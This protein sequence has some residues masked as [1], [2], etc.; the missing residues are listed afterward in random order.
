MPPDEIPTIS[1]EVITYYT[2]SYEEA[3]RFAPGTASG[4]S[5]LEFTRAQELLRARLLPLPVAILD[6]AGGPGAYVRWLTCGGYAVHLVDP[7][8]KHVD[9]ARVTDRVDRRGTDRQPVCGLVKSGPL[10]RVPS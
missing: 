2:N 8:P 1:S 6:V 7:V 3:D 9:Q 10:G 4:A 5:M